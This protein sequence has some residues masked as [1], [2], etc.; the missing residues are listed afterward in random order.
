M[1][2]GWIGTGVMGTSMVGHLL[3]AGHAVT[4][5]SRTRSK[6]QA[7]LDKG[8]TW[9]ETPAGAASAGEVVFTMVGM[10]SDVEEVYLGK[11]G[12]L[13]VARAGTI[14][15][16]MTTSSPSLAGRLASEG[17]KRGVTVLDAPVTGGDIGA[18][19]A[20][21]S[22]MVGGKAE[23][24]EQ[25]RPLLEKLGKTVLHHGAPGAG[26]HAKMVNQT[27]LAGIMLSLCE[28]LLYA[29][30]AGLDVDRVLQ[31]VGGGAAASWALANLG[32]RIVK[33]DMEAGFY[34]EHFIKDMGIVLSEAQRMNIAMPGTAITK[35]LYQAVLA[36][37]GAGK[38]TQSL[39]LALEALSGKPAATN[40]AK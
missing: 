12:I 26:Q 27:L 33:G 20:T 10:P 38:G 1:R 24:F 31:S 22:I 40:K 28:G 35:Q 23:A 37:G 36:C 16:D 8:A 32:P 9:A 2:I 13:S 4:V 39:I 11:D 3:D 17:D 25:V 30:S 5:Y 34:V 14:A 29:R 18:R 7:V 15:V 6:A 19:N 21:L